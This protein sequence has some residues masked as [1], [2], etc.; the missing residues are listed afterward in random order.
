V[1]ALKQTKCK[2]RSKYG[3]AS[4][5]FDSIDVHEVKYLPSIFDNLGDGY[6]QIQTPCIL[7]LLYLRSMLN[8][9]GS[10]CNGHYE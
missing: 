4:I 8:F 5:D 1:D 6:G 2:K 3:F 9:F 7:Q 10:E